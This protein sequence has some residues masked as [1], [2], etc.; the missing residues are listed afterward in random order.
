MEIELCGEGHLTDVM[1]LVRR[2]NQPMTTQQER[3]KG[4]RY[5]R[6]TLFTPSDFPPVASIG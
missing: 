4:N 3:S 2:C 5:L 6:I 1:V